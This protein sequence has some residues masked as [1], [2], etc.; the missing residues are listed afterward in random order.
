MRN[1]GRDNNYNKNN[2]I[3]DDFKYNVEDINEVIELYLVNINKEE[4]NKIR[5]NFC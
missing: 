1:S 3:H 4:A 5:R 2:D